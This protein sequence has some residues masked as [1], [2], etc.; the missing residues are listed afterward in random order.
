MTRHTITTTTAWLLA[1]AS[2]ADAF[3]VYTPETTSKSKSSPLIGFLDHIEQHHG[4]STSAS[5]STSPSLQRPLDGHIFQ[6]EELEGDASSITEVLINSDFTISLGKTDGPLYTE[7]H[8]TWTEQHRSLPDYDRSERTFSMKL[9]R[10]F[11]TG[12]ERSTHG[13]TAMGEFEYE[14]ERTYNGECFLVGESTL[15][16]NGEILDVDEI[17]GERRVGY[18][19][20]IDTSEG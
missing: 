15:A 4:A 2:Q 18:F 3:S 7:S 10:R 12:T 5:T 6:L 16:M 9:T 17:F 20:M 14:V 8:G 1:L 13:T 11:V 19:N